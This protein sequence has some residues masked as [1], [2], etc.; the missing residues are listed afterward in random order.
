MKK[1]LK[2]L[3]PEST[4]GA[5]RRARE[6]L[7]LRSLRAAVEEQGLSAS[8][9][10]HAEVFPEL[11]RQYT[12]FELDTE[13]LEYKVR[14]QQSFQVSLAAPVLAARPGATVV[15]I[16]DSSGAHIAALKA[17]LPDGGHRFL[18]VNLDEKA[19]ARV[20]ARGFEALLC[21]AEALSEKGVKADV[22]LSFE[23]LEHLN[24]PATFLHRLSKTACDRLVLTVPYVTETRV[25]LHHLRAGLTKTVTPETVHLF[26]LS[27]ADLKLLAAHAGWAVETERIYRQYPLNSPLR[28]TRAIWKDWDFEGFYGLVLRRDETWSSLYTGWND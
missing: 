9:R 18:S 14:A 10:R 26:E 8:V 25:G 27:P 12:D 16:G 15:D 7:L 21:R 19:V 20:K 6:S 4:R 3:L 2:T 23:T 13:F 11:S 22:F 5:L 24:D 1:L 28:G 17:M